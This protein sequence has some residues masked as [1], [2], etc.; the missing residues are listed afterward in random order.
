MNGSWQIESHDDELQHRKFNIIKL[1][2]FM[3]RKNLPVRF[4]L[5]TFLLFI[6]IYIFYD[7]FI[8]TIVKRNNFEY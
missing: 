6:Y 7:D 8:V 2:E 4:Y 5:P 3:L 1:F